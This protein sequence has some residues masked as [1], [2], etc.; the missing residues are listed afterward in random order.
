MN[1]VARDAL[2]RLLGYSLWLFLLFIFT[3]AVALTAAS[4][5][6]S[7]G[8]QAVVVGGTLV[9]LW[10][11]FAYLSKGACMKL[12]NDLVRIPVEQTLASMADRRRL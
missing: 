5:L 1:K 3:E 4:R 11:V 9:V 6:T 10:L 12:V 7:N 2:Y 8:Q